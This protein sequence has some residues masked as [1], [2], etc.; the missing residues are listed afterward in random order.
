MDSQEVFVKRKKKY[1]LTDEIFDSISR[2][3]E[4]QYE[5][6]SV[7]ID[8][9]IYAVWFLILNHALISFLIII[10]AHKINWK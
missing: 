3:W 5:I 4:V 1:Y 2:Y 8:F 7:I 9:I 10:Y 6:V